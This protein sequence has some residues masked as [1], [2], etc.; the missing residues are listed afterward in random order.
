MSDL[1][2]KDANWWRAVSDAAYGT[3]ELHDFRFIETPILESSS[4][5]ESGIGEGTDVVEK[6][7]YVFKTRGGDQVALRPEGTAPVMRSY[8]EHHLGYFAL[9]L[10]VFYIGPMFR[11]EKPQA[12][13][14]RQFHS[15][16]IEIIGD[17]DP[18]Y[19]AEVIVAT[20][21]FLRALKL[22]NLT[23]KINTIGCRVCRP[24]YRDR[25]K[26]YYQS[27]RSKLCRDCDRRLDKNI[28]RLLDC[29]EEK[30]AP[31][32]A[33]API[34]FD[35]LCQGCNN[36]FKS[37]LEFIEDASLVYEPDPYLVRGLDYYN[38][39]VFEIFSTT[40]PTIGALGGGGRY[41]YLGELMGGRSVPGVG[42]GTGLERI[43]EAMKAESVIP[44]IKTK[45]RVYFTAVGEQARKGSF[46]I[47]N[48]LRSNGVAVLESLGK[49]SLKAQLKV[50]DK[51]GAPIALIF[52]QREVF[53]GTIII[54]DMGS[55]A[56]ETVALD[57]LVEI[58]KKRFRG[59]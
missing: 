33:Q 30:C 3:A 50:A 31:I 12:G 52:G 37:V 41:D 18:I 14:E 45:P 4:L 35:H 39:T 36:H 7:M 46:R 6:Q 54:R 55:G 15:W 58:T 57:K 24:G 10:K 34:V 56:Q 29:K 21:D 38:R 23:L 8:F 19:D 32:K 42:A 26:S 1:L 17:N 9:P 40:A 27:N 28:L 53:E 44:Q 13:R 20:M 47:M 48:N 16:G 43:I 49:K 59:Q 11:Y 22:K 5:F 25:L 51:T 2:P